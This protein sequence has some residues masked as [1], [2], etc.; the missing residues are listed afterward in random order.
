MLQN[1]LLLVI[2]CANQFPL[3]ETRGN[4][5]F[6][7][8][9]LLQEAPKIKNR[10]EAERLIFKILAK[11]NNAGFPFCKIL[12]AV[13]ESDSGLTKIILT[14]DEGARVIIDDLLFKTGGKTDADAAKRL[15]N[16]KA[17]EYFSASKIDRVIKRLMNTGAFENVNESVIDRDGRQF[18]MLTL[19]ERDSDVLTLSGSLSGEDREFG[20]SFSSFNLLGTLRKLDFDYEYQRLFALKVHEPVLISPAHIDADFSILTYDSTRLIAGQVKFGAPIGEYFR[21]SLL[22]GIEVVNHYESDTTVFESSDNLLG[23]GLGF[24]YEGTGWSVTHEISLDYLFRTADRLKFFY[25]GDFEFWKI[26]IRPHYRYVRTDVFDFFD[27]IRIGGAKDLR[28]YL[29]DEFAVKKVFWLNLEY[30]RLFIFPLI[31]IARIDG[32]MLFSYGFGVSAKSRLADASLML[33]WPK[34]GTWEDGKIHL[35]LARGF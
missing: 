22:S 12:P 25:D 15:A 30:H 23:I 4:V 21:I 5:F 1:I 9:Y 16:F 32:D 2:V 34:G 7:S 17:G 29:E 13:E 28:G 11:Y 26:N 8:K 35:S 6:S 10:Q 14:I 27:Y 18:V 19:Y 24:D 33:A 31:D 3:V 20:A